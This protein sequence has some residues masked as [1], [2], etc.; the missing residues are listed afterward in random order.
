[1]DKYGIDSQKL[2]YHPRRV[3]EWLE[4]G[5]IYPLYIEVG[6]V[7]RCQQNCVFCAFDYLKNKNGAI[8]DENYCKV[9][10]MHASQ[11]G[12]KAIMYAGEGEPL[13][14]PGIET[15]VS[16]TK[17][18]NIDVSMTTNGVKLDERRT[19]RFL[20]F[21][22]WLRFSV[23]AATP[24]TYAKVHG[25]RKEH[26]ARLDS[27]IR[28]TVE[29][30]RELHANCTIGV[31]AVLIPQNEDEITRLARLAWSWGVDYFAVKPFSKHPS[32][33]CDFDMEYGRLK[34]LEEQLRP[35]ATDDFKII[36][37]VNAME[38]LDQSRPYEECLA[39]SFAT[40]VDAAGYVYPCSMF[41]GQVEYTYGN[42]Y[43]ECFPAIWEGKR[44]QCVMARLRQ[45]G[46]DRCREI[47]RLDEVNRYLWAL[48]H[49]PEHVN[50]I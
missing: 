44:R 40:Y 41:L 11:M 2:I 36:F 5:L 47:C 33:I 22:N 48:K 20:P 7:A 49:P 35:I 42:I 37:R 13:L 34:V 10:T 23:D 14:H 45:E 12:V 31:Q 46:V 6:P 26:F 29:I 19:L 9:L 30:K 32:S 18:H 50:F 21:L 17:M 16:N 39:L 25:C 24:E 28:R 4:G 27:N 38:K 8:L 43:E 15:I 1:M 3:A